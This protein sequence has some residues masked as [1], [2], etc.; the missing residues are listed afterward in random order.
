[1]KASEFKNITYKVSSQNRWT[2]NIPPI[3]DFVNLYIKN[4]KGKV[5][6]LFSGE[7]KIDRPNVINNHRYEALEFIKAF[8]N[9]Y[10]DLILFDPPYAKHYA[11]LYK[12]PKIADYNKW[13]WDIKKQ[14]ARTLKVGGYVISTGYETNG[15][16]A[17][18]GFEK[19]EILIVAHGGLLRDTFCYSEKKIKDGWWDRTWNNRNDIKYDREYKKLIVDMKVEIVN[20]G[21]DKFNDFWKELWK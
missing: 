4:T 3:K 19:K 2:Y 21:L 8:P 6:N 14:I 9:N 7:N 1:M 13:I 20:K 15:I 12:C 17:L 11:K 5:L 16:G 18:K 10:F